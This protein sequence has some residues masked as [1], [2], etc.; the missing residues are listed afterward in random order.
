MYA[1]TGGG[2]RSRESQLSGRAIQR[3]TVPGWPSGWRSIF[4]RWTGDHQRH[5]AR[6]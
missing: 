1:E 6:R 4:P 5:G 2:F 3:R